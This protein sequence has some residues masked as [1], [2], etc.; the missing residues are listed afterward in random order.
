LTRAVD[1]VL[2]Y[3]MTEPHSTDDGLT[4][5]ILRDLSA[6]A[7]RWIEDAEVDA[8]LRE[9]DEVDPDLW[10]EDLFQIRV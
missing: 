2:F 1:A 3:R 8:A 9:Q 7:G 10:D 5:P 4:G 6:F